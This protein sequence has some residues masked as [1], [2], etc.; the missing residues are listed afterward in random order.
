[1]RKGIIYGYSFGGKM[2]YIGQTVNKEERH[3]FHMVYNPYNKE[4]REYEYPFC[5]AVRKYGA[6][7]F[8]LTVLEDGVDED[9]L[10]EREIFYIDKYDT[11]RNGYNQTSGGSVPTEVKYEEDVVETVIQMLIDNKG[12]EEINR[13]TGISFPHISNINQGKRRRREDL[14]YPLRADA[15]GIKGGKLIK[16][17]VDEIIDLIKYTKFSLESIGQKYGVSQSI[18]SH[19]KSGR[20]RGTSTTESYPLKRQ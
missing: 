9:L 6:E 12:F 8:E 4:C 17:D 5:R 7:S 2:K 20:R 14:K 10:N 15:V 3:L 18:I 13:A 16:K 1:M 19:I 11:Y